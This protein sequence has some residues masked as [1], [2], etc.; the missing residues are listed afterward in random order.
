MQI[1]QRQ[2]M[3]QRGRRD[4]ELKMTI[5]SNIKI[6]PSAEREGAERTRRDED[7]IPSNSKL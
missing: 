6:Y 1:N 4:E 7:P 3:G 2:A 5:K